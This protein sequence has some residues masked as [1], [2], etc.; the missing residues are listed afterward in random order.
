MFSITKTKDGGLAISGLCGMN[1]EG[2]LV[3]A[4]WPLICSLGIQPFSSIV[5][6]QLLKIE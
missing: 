6:S 3:S 5:L 4:D 1:A 2:T